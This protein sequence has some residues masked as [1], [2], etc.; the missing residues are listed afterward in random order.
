MSTVLSGADALISRPICREVNP[1]L[2]DAA[3]ASVTAGVF[4]MSA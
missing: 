1:V 3:T 2:T 4:T